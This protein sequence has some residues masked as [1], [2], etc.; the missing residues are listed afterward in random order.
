MTVVGRWLGTEGHADMGGGPVSACSVV[1]L[2]GCAGPSSYGEWV[3]VVILA[4]AVLMV[5]VVAFVHRRFE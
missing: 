1:L 4:W 3:A 5:L 2:A